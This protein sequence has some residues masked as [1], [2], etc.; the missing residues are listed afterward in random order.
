MKRIRR[1]VELAC[2]LLLAATLATV[3]GAGQPPTCSGAD[4]RLTPDYRYLVGSAGYAD[5]EGDP[6]AGSTFRWLRNG[7]TL[8]AG[9]VAE[10]LRLHFDGAATG[11]N[12]EAPFA[13]ANVQFHSGKWTSALA[14]PTNGL[15][16]FAVPNNLDVQQGTI[17]MWVALREDGT[18][19]SYSTRNHVLLH[20]RAP[21][22]DYLQIAQSRTSGILYVGG[23]VSN[24]WESAY[25]SRGD[26]RSWRAGQWHHLAFTYSAAANFMRFYVDGVEAAA[27]NEGHYWPPAGDGAAFAIGGDLSPSGNA[28]HYWIDECRFSGRVAEADEIAARFRRET[29]SEPNEVWLPAS[30]VAPGDSLVFEFTPATPAASGAPCQSALLPFVGI[31][32]VS[33]QPPSTLLAAGATSLDLSVRTAI[34]TSC[35]YAVGQPLPFAQMTP[36]ASGAGS[37]QHQVHVAG[38]SPDPQIV[39]DVF[40]RCAS[41]PDY[42]M[43]LRYRA[44]SGVN[45]PFPRTG[46]LWGWWQW[47][48]KGLPYMARVDLWLGAEP[49][50]DEIRELRRLNPHLRL[51]TSINAVENSG[52]PADYYLRDVNGQRIEVWPGSFRLNLTKPYVAEYQARFAYE[53]VLATDLMADGVFFDNVMTTQSWQTQDIYG[54]PVQIDA[55]E[56]GVADDPAAF[57]A[58]WKDGVFHE[59]RAFR[60]LMP[61]AIVNGHSMNIYESGIAELFNGISL[62]FV[63][64]NV[65][66]GEESFAAVWNRYHDWQARA[67]QPVGTMVE[68]SPRDQIA[69]GYDYEPL[70]KIPPATLDFA[71]TYYPDVRFGLA[72]TLMNDGFFAHEYGDTWHGNDWWYDE[73]DFELGYPLGPAQRVGL[74]GSV[75]TNGIVNPGFESAIATPWRL[76]VN[77]GC[78]ARLVRQTTE[79]PEGTACARVDIT[80]TTGTD[81]HIEFAQYTRSLTQ[82]VTYDF[83]FHARGSAARPLTVSAQ[84]SSPD[85]RGYGLHQELWLTDQWQAFTVPFTATETVTD[86]RLQFF[87]GESTDT[88]WIDD[89]RLTVHPPDV[90]RRDFTQGIV[91]LNGTRE[92]R[93]VTL[94]PGFHRL[95]GSQA[96]MIERIIDDKDPGFAMTGTWTNRSYDSGEWKASGPFYHS[97]AGG[98]R[99]RT[100]TTGEAQWT[101]PIELD[102]T[103]TIAA[104]WPAAPAGTNWTPQAHYEI[105]SGGAVVASTNLNQRLDGDQWHPLATVAL[106]A[107]NVT[108]VRLTVPSGA[109]VADAIYVRSAA[110]YNNGQPVDTIRLQPMD[111]IV[112]ARTQPVPIRPRLSQIAAATTHVL[113]TASDLTPGLTN[114]LQRSP[115]LTPVEWS[116]R[117]SFLATG[118]MA[119]IAD[120]ATNAGGFYRLSLP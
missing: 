79:A 33:A 52:L 77:T 112:L 70:T 19:A 57:D 82:G 111:G 1:A 11:G 26:M 40:V 105:V 3:H 61:H 28:A 117:T 31:P 21:N 12:G 20:Y 29:P 84:K 110:R 72:F 119:T 116:V 97:W 32:I 8:Q 102:D 94:G 74:P 92:V 35:A 87:L 66:E 2:G 62:G 68:S 80:A 53:T 101:L 60:E 120:S 22:G 58:A 37:A 38:L 36:F 5:A 63:T 14:L 39:N 42:V 51:L 86:A 69:Y 10:G 47:R 55:N 115:S 108:F 6:E 48:S 23:T 98:L 43:R 109:G 91:L 99:E 83:S 88:V 76:N 106:T 49:P 34:A 114:E 18:N 118:Y 81:W 56:D 54:N 93:D 16:R 90:F 9:S 71:R 46:N 13:A 24:Q 73:L 50:A 41:H 27:N 104:W 75:G 113:L 59:I 85:W 67:V 78:A 30:Q 15:L 4:L 100:S 17:E 65:L 89:V 107:T 7:A 64:A 103:Y 95:T 96:P 44:L 25:G 45:P